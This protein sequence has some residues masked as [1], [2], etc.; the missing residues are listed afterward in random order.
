[1]HGVTYNGHEELTLLEL[2]LQLHDECRGNLE[3]IR[4]KPL[5][6]GML[7]FLRHHAD[8]PVPLLS[9]TWRPVKFCRTQRVSQ[10]PVKESIEVLTPGRTKE[11][12]VSAPFLV[13]PVSS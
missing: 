11:W 3:P 1:M 13:P 5:Q 7:L 2:V 10:H 4:V 6:T 8:A 12:N 9:H